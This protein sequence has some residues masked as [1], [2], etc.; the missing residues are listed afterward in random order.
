MGRSTVK[1]GAFF[2]VALIVG[3]VALNAGV[4]YWKATHPAPPP[5]PTVGFGTLP[6][7]RFPDQQADQKPHSYKLETPN[8]GLP[9]FGDRAKVFLMTKSAPSLLAD[10]KA[11]AFAATYDFVFKPEVLNA[12]TYRW[13]KTQ[14]LLSTLELNINTDHFKL[15]TNFLSKPELIV[16]TQLPTGFDAVAR[17]KQFLDANKLLQR[18]IA[19][20]SGE[21][22][23]LKSLG[24]ELAPAVSES[25]A[26][27]VQ[28]DLNRQPIDNRFRMF[29]PN[30]YQGIVS[31]ILSGGFS[32]R[33]SIVQLEYHY[34]DIDYTEVHTYPIRSAQS[35]W[36]LLQAGEGYVAD[37][38]T[39]DQA[40]VRS[41]SMGY[42]DDFEEQQYL[43]PIYV[44]E[45]DGNFLAFI[46]ALDAQWIQ[47]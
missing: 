26:D 38:G 44:F 25:D 18:D 1:Y 47:K 15:T 4:A 46:P 28:V 42:Y 9:L 10:E 36:Q 13:T 34:N 19:T 20:A 29:T 5:P 17:V 22:V 35:A 45:G 41:V 7:L 2:I 23:Y 27:F 32:D 31:A 39:N 30:G 3:R 37:K 33:D 21:I 14:P 6:P 11:K 40:V 8:G 24:G 16:N 12:D 43:Q